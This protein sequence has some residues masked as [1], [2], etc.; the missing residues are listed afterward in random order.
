MVLEVAVHES[1]AHAKGK[2]LKYLGP[3]TAVQ[4]VVVLLVR[5]ALRGADRLQ[6]LSFERGQASPSWQRSFADPA[7]SR[8]GDPSFALRLP[9]RLLFDCAPMPT[10]R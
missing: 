3:D 7:C 4:I 8:A 9:V 2:A 10:W 1:Y 6:A 5:P